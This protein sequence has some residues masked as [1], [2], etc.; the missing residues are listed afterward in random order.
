MACDVRARSY[1]Q[2]LARTVYAPIVYIHEV[3]N[4]YRCT[5][6]K[7]WIF[8]GK[9]GGV[10][11]FVNESTFHRMLSAWFFLVFVKDGS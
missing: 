11:N 3:M 4:V 1:E 10:A 7:N 8:K 6:C 5:S 9:V 2:Y